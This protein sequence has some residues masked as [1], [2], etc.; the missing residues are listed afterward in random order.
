MKKIGIVL[1]LLVSSLLITAQ[2]AS[3]KTE[4]DLQNSEQKS[5]VEKRQAEELAQLTKQL[6]LTPEQQAS[7]VELQQNLNNAAKASREATKDDPERKAKRKQMMLLRKEYDANVMA[8][9]TPKQ[10]KKYEAILKQEEMQRQ[11]GNQE[12]QG[13]NQ[14][15]NNGDE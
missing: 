12:S 8:L 4:K 1:M 5:A 7:I 9:L 11:N 13:G 10:K 3:S 15:S 2:E 6:T 14:N